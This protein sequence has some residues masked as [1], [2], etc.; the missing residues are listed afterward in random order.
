MYGKKFL[1]QRLWYSL[2][3]LCTK[4]YENPSIF[5]KVTVK[6]SVAPFFL[7]TVY[8]CASERW[9]DKARYRH[10]VHICVCASERWSDKAR[11]IGDKELEATWLLCKAWRLWWLLWWS[12]VVVSVHF[13]LLYSTSSCDVLTCSAEWLWTD[14]VWQT[15]L[16]RSS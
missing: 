2:V 5:V 11:S 3:K 6:K 13:A 16:V 9:S 12:V 14:D 8:V 4:N 7:D 15:S 10:C 1:R